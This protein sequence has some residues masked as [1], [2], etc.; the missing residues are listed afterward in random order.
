MTYTGTMEL[1]HFGGENTGQLKDEYFI[2]PT[3]IDMGMRI[4]HTIEL[5]DIETGLEL[6]GGVK[7]IFDAYQQDFDINKN[8]DSN[9]IYG[10][11]LPRT[12]FFG[13]RVKP[14]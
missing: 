4:G 14:I 11:S 1:A 8:R 10:P 6:F 9:Y 13:V 3:F 12:L 7:N 5:N 2:S